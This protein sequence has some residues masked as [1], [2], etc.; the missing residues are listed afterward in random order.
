MRKKIVHFL[1][2][3]LLTTFCAANVVAQNVV[4]GKVVDAESNEP[5]IGASVMV[6][7]TTQGVV[8]D[9]DG[10]FT[11]N[12]KSATK[13]LLFKYIGYRNLKMKIAQT[14][15]VDLGVVK[16]EAD[17]VALGD[18]TITS[19]IAVQRKTPVAVSTVDP[20]F[21]EEKLGT[22][23]FPEILKSTPGVYATKQ[24]GGYGD[25][26]INL[27]GFESANIA[28]MV[29]GIPMNDMEWG[30]VYWSNWAGLS[31]VTR[32]MQVQRGL[33][34][35]KICA[36]SVGGSIN[37]VT[38]TTDAVKG[39][40]L[41][42]GVGNDGYNKVGFSL[43]TGMNDKGWAY[44]ILGTK[45]WGDGYV[46]G[47]AF[48]AYSWFVNLS[49]K[50]NDS[51]TLSLTAL[52]APQ[53]HN[54]R[55]DKLTIAE[56]EK[57]SQYGHRYN[58]IYGFDATGQQR[59]SSY[60][61]YHK[62]QISLNHSWQ[63]N[64]KSSLSTSLY[65]S[66]GTGGGYS[67]QGKNKS[68]FYG[69]TNGIPNTT[70]RR[71]DGTFD[72]ESLMN[73]NAASENGSLAAMSA[74][75]NNHIWYGLLSTYTRELTNSLSLQAGIDLRYYKGTHTNKLVDLYGGQFFIDP[76]RASSSNWRSSDPDYVNQK[77]KVGD[78]VY[79]DYDG[80]V[81]QDGAF[82]Q[83]EYTKDKLSAFLSG[84][85]NNNSYW[86]RDRFYY[87]NKK[88]EVVNKLGF[89]AKGGANYNLDE[90]NN[91][92]ANVG[93]FSRTPFFS[94]GI[95]LSS[96]VSNAVNPSCKNEKVFSYEAGYGYRSKI[97]TANVNVYRTA[98]KDKSMTKAVVSSDAASNYLNMN[99]VNALHQGVELDCKFHPINELT[100]TGM[101]SLGNWKWD[102]NATGYWYNKEGEALD[103]S[104]NVVAVGSANQAVATL[105]LKGLHV[106]NSAQT[107]AAMGINYEFMKGL[108]FGLDG[109]YY[110]RNFS[111]YDISLADISASGVQS[112]AQPWRIPDALVFDFNTSYRF[113]IGGLDAS[114]IANVENLFNEKYITDAQDNGAKTGGHGWQD[115][116]VFYGFGRT[117]STTL[118]IK[119]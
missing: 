44:T 9:L 8:T 118:K 85:I 93:F 68:S 98:W 5:L 76:S 62:P 87:D 54:Q 47:T 31:D 14:K 77:L 3:A 88:S 84:N 37:V 115:A 21:I 50:I 10:S 72:Y 32:S 36:P 104:G 78:I 92:F 80:F 29:N 33:G 83:L 22:Q 103:K 105:N 23:E 91:V 110:G 114:L 65:M 109:T 42:Y 108:R 79:R 38:K 12:V 117:W 51:Q 100:I 61:F 34:A 4:K 95:F 27:R 111:N 64:D 48:N 101:L 19:S 97:F 15:N 90:H 28:V 57:Q 52:G 39:G 89:G 112:F 43:S 73:A 35:S 46:Q 69:A 53:W 45:T 49:K 41:Q 24:S 56:W 26:R 13:T 71:N 2:V 20:V 58:A 106:G 40:S 99:G 86:R 96:V 113:K 30:G 74:S 7:G 102:S 1:L 59:T 66:I 81:T 18:I 63:I 17:A 60:N 11:L 107:T 70:Y 25:S 67:G 6:E 116:T 55:Y 119:F 75:M 82:A 94:G 16:M